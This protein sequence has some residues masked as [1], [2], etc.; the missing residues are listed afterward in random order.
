MD[1]RIAY[2]RPPTIGY[3]NIFDILISLLRDSV[4][5]SDATT[6]RIRKRYCINIALCI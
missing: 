1:R 6:R 5:R 3:R 2:F 4:M